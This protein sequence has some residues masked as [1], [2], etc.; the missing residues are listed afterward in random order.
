MNKLYAERDIIAQKEHYVKHVSAMTDEGLYSKSDIATELAHRDITIAGLIS[1]M[2]IL[3][4]ALEDTG[5]EPRDEFFAVIR[6]VE[7]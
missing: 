2:E 6:E 7:G 1:E 4:N 5:H 3:A